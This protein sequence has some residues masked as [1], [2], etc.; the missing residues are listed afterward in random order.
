[1]LVVAAV[2]VLLWTPNSA[3][4]RCLLDWRAVRRRAFWLLL[5]RVLPR[6]V[7]PVVVS[8]DGSFSSLRLPPRGFF[9]RGV[10]A[11]VLFVVELG[12]SRR[13]VRC[14]VLLAVVL[15]V[16]VV[17]LAVV[18][19]LEQRILRVLE[20][21]FFVRNPF[22]RLLRRLELLEGGPLLLLRHDD[23][24]PLRGR[25]GLVRFVDDDGGDRFR[26]HEGQLVD[27]SRRRRR[28]EPAQRAQRRDFFRFEEL[29]FVGHAAA[30]DFVVVGAVQKRSAAF[31][32]QHAVQ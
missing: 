29:A 4:R 11:P 7:A 31:H 27:V 20:R 24:P 2:V 32:P 18:F 30:N 28:C 22:G 1:M 19:S 3:R 6:V 5:P 26:K 25:G 21:L 17:P 13:R 9:P 16:V 8:L 14:G 10:V 23:S 15:A 12:L